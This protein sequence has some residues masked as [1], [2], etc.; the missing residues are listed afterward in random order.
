MNRL[1]ATLRRIDGKGFGA[2]KDLGGVYRGDD[3]ELRVDHI[4]GD[5]FAAPSR[6]ALRRPLSGVG[7]PPALVEG[8]NAIAVADFLTRQVAL[9]LPHVCRGRRGSGKSGTVRIDAPKQEILERTSAV[10]ADGMVEIRLEVGLPA[11]GRRILGRHAFEML[12]RELPAVADRALSA[13]HLPL[14]ALEAHLAAALDQRAARAQ[15][16]GAGL[17]AFVAEGA[18]LPRLSGVDPRP[19]SG[20]AVPFGPVPDSLRV[21]LRL[22]HAGD[23][24]GLGIPAGVTVIVG[25]GFHGKSTLL[26]AISLGIYDHIPGDGREQV[27][28]IG[29]TMFVRA[30]DGRRVTGVDISPFISDLPLGRATTS[31]TTDDASG[32]TSEAAAIQEAVELGAKLL[33]IDEDTSASNF[34]VRDHRMQ[35]LVE[36]EQEPITPFIDRVTELYE[37][38]GVSTIMVL[39]GASDYLDV[40]HT[41]VHMNN[42]RPLDV[43]RRAKE[44]CRLH[45]NQRRPEGAAPYIL[46]PA[47]VPAPES[48]DP[49]HGRR[50][51]RVKTRATR[52]I[53][54]GKTEI[55]LDGLGQLVDDSQARAI[56][57]LLL[58][59]SRDQTHAQRSLSELVAA[60]EARVQAEGLA[61]VLA[62][63]MGNRAAV[64]SL[65]LGATINRMR[66]L[67]IP[68]K[69]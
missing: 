32:S 46:P 14:A 54:F 39:G 69:C 60:L 49:S 42:Y 50:P 6:F 28:S 5:P 68:S 8:D 23:V 53:R 12:A 11:E 51:E 41:V 62:P 34:L 47:R 4:Q 1:E 25:G 40:A 22:P 29:E 38:A 21:T 63:G 66:T 15:L 7:V 16:A 45:P 44:I 31:F 67:D 37:V 64:R 10:I 56:G 33:L 57:D 9:A 27:V 13:K 20:A 61:A 2:Y 36:K 43:T 52:S 24:S 48:F 58:V 65:D 55:E 3:I 26:D 19:L 35:L 30:E 17:V 18:T 59:L